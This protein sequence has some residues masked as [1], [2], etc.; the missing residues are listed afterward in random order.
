MTAHAL[1]VGAG[2]FPQPS[3][4]EEDRAAG[5]VV[6]RPLPSVAQAVPEVARA[7]DAAGVRVADLL[8]DPTLREWEDA[9][10]RVREEAG[11]EPVIVH[12]G[13]HGLVVDTDLYLAVSDTDPRPG[14]VH[15]SAVDVE[16]L[17]RTV[18]RG[19]GGPVLFLLDVCGA[20]AALRPQLVAKLAGV[21]HRKAWVIAACPAE[22][23]TY[24]AR[25]STA[26]AAVLEDLAQRR[27]FVGSALRYVPVEQ[28]AARIDQV[29]ARADAARGEPKQDVVRTADDAAVLP[30]PPFLANPY[31]RSRASDAYLAHLDG[32]LDHFAQ[33]LDPR[34]DI[35]HF[36]GRAAGGAG[37]AGVFRF[38]GRRRQLARLREWLDG[39]AGTEDRLLVVTG[40]PGAGK[41][42]LL[43]V[44]V[45]SVHPELEGLRARLGL[46]TFR[47][48]PDPRLLAVH[49]RQL[50]TRQVVDSLHRQI[51]A[52]V[53]GPADGAPYEPE[54]AVGTGELFDTL[55][56]AGGATVVVDALDEADDPEELL[57][58]VL[59]PLAGCPDPGAAPGCRVLLGTRLW[60]G[61]LR[62]LRAVLEGR[63]ALRI[64]LDDERP[65]VLADDLGVY[66][67]KLLDP[68]YPAGTAREL[69]ARL[70]HS[71]EQGAFLTAFLYGTHLRARHAAGDPPDSEEAVAGLPLDLPGMLDL[72]LRTL[73]AENP[74]TGPVL[75][76]VGRAAG[77]GMPLELVHAVALALAPAARGPLPAPRPDDT[78]AALDHARFYLRRTAD[79]DRPVYRFFHQA[80]ADRMAPLAAPGAV[81]RALLEQVPVVDGV[82]DWSAADPYLRRHAADHAAE[83][84]AEAL[85]ALLSD[86]GHLLHA[87]PERLAPHLHRARGARARRH[88]D[89][90]RQTTAHH[91]LRHSLTARRDLLA[92]EAAVWQD[93]DLAAALGAATGPP[94]PLV[95]PH[96]A[97]SRTA[98][99]ARL[100][101]LGPHTGPVHRV[102]LT[103]ASGGDA[104]TAVAGGPEARARTEEVTRETS[105]PVRSE[106]T[107]GV[108][109]AADARAHDAGTAGADGPEDQART[110]EVARETGDP[111]RS[112]DTSGVTAAADARAHDAGTAG[113]GGPEARARTEDVAHETGG[114]AGSGDT[115]GVTAAA[116]ARARAGEPTAT[117]TGA[118]R[119]ARTG[120]KAVVTA[121]AGG[122]VRRWDPLRGEA[123]GGLDGI[124]GPVRAADTVRDSDGR[125]LLVC[126]GEDRLTVHDL[127]TGALRHRLAL[128]GVPPP[129]LLTALTLPDGGARAVTAGDGRTVQVW[130][131]DAGRL[132]FT[133]D[134][135][136]TVVRAL[137]AGTL[138]DGRT[139]MLAAGD[140]YLAMVWDLSTGR[141]LHRLGPHGDF[142]RA[143]ALA[144]RTDGGA[145]AVTGGA[146]ARLHVW[147]LSDG[148]ALHTLSGHRDWI[149]ALAAGRAGG[150][151]LAV[152]GDRQGRL[153]V[154]DLDTGR[155]V[156]ELPGRQGVITCVALSGDVGAGLVVA[157]CADGRVAV[158]DLGT[159][160]RTHGFA[161]H[162]SG[163]YDVAV[164]R[165]EDRLVVV[166]GGGDGRAV[167]WDVTPGEAG[168][169]AAPDGVAVA[170]GEARAGAA[171][172][173]GT[174]LGWGGPSAAVALCVPRTG[175]ALLVT[176]DGQT[177][178][179]RE[180]TTGRRRFRLALP[181]P[182]PWGRAMAAAELQDLGRVAVTAGRDGVVRTWDLTTGALACSFAGPS[183]RIR[184]PAVTS[185]PGGRAVLVAGED[186]GTATVRDLTT[187]ELLAVFPGHAGRLRA[188]TTPDVPGAPPAAVSADDS[189]AVLLWDLLSGEP[190]TVLTRTG[191]PVHAVAAAALPDGRAVVVAGGAGGEVRLWDLSAPGAAEHLTGLERRVNVLATTRLADGT[192]VAVGGGEDGRLAFWDLA[193]RTELRPSYHLPGAVTA[194]A[195][196]PEGI[197]VA[198]TA[199]T[200][201]LG[202]TAGQPA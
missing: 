193:A 133:R 82:R 149:T 150:R 38:S 168:G 18:D 105:D 95:R 180:F 96:W 77:S 123:L 184:T 62:E 37:G 170:E 154:W 3:S 194:L 152:S 2:G 20:G 179:A 42:A 103:D 13:G 67:E 36:A 60:P 174:A 71:V 104:G 72:N 35:V 167:V 140:E 47:P 112:E 32:G 25:F 198:H 12:F 14:F 136:M 117:T 128:N 63:P 126:A 111:V 157:G 27:V 24:G 52:A 142:V 40:S 98:A 189:G 159:G 166:S 165:V 43:G 61:A 54:R 88:A 156:R 26:V 169:E 106:D 84:G 196:C 94:P 100:H 122:R 191:P 4:G 134:S 76:A 119:R 188:L 162:P 148:H 120:S 19:P 202:W 91:P 79:G 116:D 30:P 144:R 80:L 138:P 130:D 160:V 153:L 135:P 151:C 5:R 145:V 161:A 33:A 121:W 146:D 118:E 176:A 23:I 59:L 8:L 109:A 7:L 132:L 55:A 92:L 172:V 31:Y 195:A 81:L 147:D 48:R 53:A 93:T 200:A 9:W 197:A 86:A 15:G 178:E 182:V 131:L 83:A 171:G 192:V 199:G 17:L 183:R 97:L 107:G 1:V 139:A 102:L 45:C 29:M 115:A 186:D 177:L 164:G 64:D 158:W 58:E 124:D 74:W 87:E 181:A 56:R 78:R 201:A 113:A 155:P 70:A 57:R 68:H 190:I 143:A 125:L 185:L 44:A 49:A 73:R 141:R 50:T 101:T 114:A 11:K 89:V 108:T 6:L 90:Y 85:D 41:S 187:G 39:P 129:S 34:F 163:V 175:P 10:R 110:E 21:R 99:A 65:Q 127:G 28:L 16:L 22:E 173:D 69:A 51:L 137:V 46:E 75:A 66:L